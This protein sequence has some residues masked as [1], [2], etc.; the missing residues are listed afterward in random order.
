MRLPSCCSIALSNSEARHGLF[1][2]RGYVHRFLKRRGL[3]KQQAP[4]KNTFRQLFAKVLA[5]VKFRDGNVVKHISGNHVCDF[6][7]IYGIF[8]RGNHQVCQWHRKFSRRKTTYI[9]IHRFSF[10]YYYFLP[11][12]RAAGLNQ[13]CLRYWGVIIFFLMLLPVAGSVL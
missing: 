3:K 7:F 4:A 5:K 6:N 10:K 9:G 1:T 2:R 8:F 11:I 13:K 12:Y